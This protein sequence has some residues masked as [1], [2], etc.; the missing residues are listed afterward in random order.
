[1][2]SFVSPIISSL[3][4]KKTGL[5]VKNEKTRFSS[6]SGKS[7]ANKVL[8]DINFHEK[9]ST[10]IEDEIWKNMKK[11]Q[12][13]NKSEIQNLSSIKKSLVFVKTNYTKALNIESKMYEIN[14]PETKPPSVKIDPSKY[15]LNKRNENEI[16]EKSIQDTLN[17]DFKLESR[18]KK[19]V[20]TKP[21]EIDFDIC[22]SQSISKAGEKKF[23]DKYSKISKESSLLKNPKNT[24]TNIVKEKNV[25][26]NLLIETAISQNSINFEERC[27]YGKYTKTLSNN[28]DISDT[29]KDL[30]DFQGEIECIEP[31]K[32]RF[33]QDSY[34][35]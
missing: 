30:K 35:V 25:N 6:C 24:M 34:D 4:R 18:N 17:N 10:S 32:K 7:N 2:N 3:K 13:E 27:F 5:K 21:I 8:Q 20:D 14:M 33:L 1:M 16:E 29:K 15:M 12:P 9:D 26:Q 31:P 11:L 22:N 19:F 23:E 28:Y